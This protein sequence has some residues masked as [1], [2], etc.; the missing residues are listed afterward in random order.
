[1]LA[2]TFIGGYFM[3]IT[4]ADM[5]ELENIGKKES[6]TVQDLNQ[7]VEIW[8][9]NHSALRTF[10]DP[11]RWRAK[12]GRP[13]SIVGLDKMSSNGRGALEDEGYITLMQLIAIR[14]SE[15]SIS[16]RNNN[17]H[18]S[19]IFAKLAAVV[20]KKTKIDDSTPLDRFFFML[21]TIFVELIPM[22][23]HDFKD[24]TVSAIESFIAA[25]EEFAFREKN[26]LD[27]AGYNG[28][29][30]VGAQ[31]LL[32]Q[33]ENYGKEKLKF[34]L[35]QLVQCFKGAFMIA[36][37]K[38]RLVQFFRFFESRGICIAEKMRSVQA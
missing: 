21:R 15:G 36:R 37:E 5:S 22:H 13:N 6:L 14:R 2:K 18:S 33:P 32:R 34:T 38:D 3:T 4:V 28:T 7:C 29:V 35:Q 10:F 17:S 26:V 19:I 23:P 12:E 25:M 11:G 24:W 30:R 1:M 16:S 31:Y 9:R 27:R 8:D 20:A